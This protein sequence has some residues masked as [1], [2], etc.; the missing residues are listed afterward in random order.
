VPDISQG[1]AAMQL[2]CGGIFNDDFVR[3]LPLSIKVKTFENR[4]TFGKFT[5]KSKGQI[6]FNSVANGVVFPI[7][8]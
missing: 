8:P 5:G 6:F 7:T 3:N 2:K 4:S 1:S